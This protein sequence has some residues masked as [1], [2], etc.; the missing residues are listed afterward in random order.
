MII[1]AYPRPHAD[2]LLKPTTIYIPGGILYTSNQ[3]LD[4][5]GFNWDF[6]DGE[7]SVE[8]NP[9]HIY[10]QEGQYTVTLEATNEHGC[11]DTTQMVNAVIVKKGGQ[12]L[13]P[14]A[15]SPA[16]PGTSSGGLSDGKNDVFLPLT[17]GV[18]E[19]ELLIFNRWGQLL[20]ES[21]SPDKGW[22]GYYNGKLCEQDVYVYRFTG[23]YDNGEKI[24]RVGDVNLI[25]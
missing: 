22:D 1:E 11:M 4:A 20:F 6:G 18:V 7:T 13:F 14:N 5:M 9:Q 17:R 8:V 2:F 19:F 16:G 15:F 3:S 25:R 10:K 24:V 21:H 12:V 23:L